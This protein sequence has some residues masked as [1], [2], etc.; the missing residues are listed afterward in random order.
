M[1]TLCR[2]ISPSLCTVFSVLTVAAAQ[3]SGS[4]TILVSHAGVDR[5]G[6]GGERPGQQAGLRGRH[7]A[8]GGGG[9]AHLQVLLL[10]PARTIQSLLRDNSDSLAYDGSRIPDCPELLANRS[11]YLHRHQHGGWRAGP[12]HCTV[13]PRLQQVLGVQPAGGVSA[14]VR[15]LPRHRPVPGRRRQHAGQALVRLQV[16]PS[17]RPLP[18]PLPRPQVPVS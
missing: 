14:A 6:D 3:H 15:H 18:R 13:L 17:P 1:T 12:D 4:A 8:A 9:A 16:R 11:S 10:D 5:G 2:L 7:L